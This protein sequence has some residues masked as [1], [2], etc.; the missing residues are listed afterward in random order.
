MAF[1]SIFSYKYSS[2]SLAQFTYLLALNECPTFPTPP[3]IM[4]GGKI[5]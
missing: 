5:D 3:N 1:F 4:Q 2:V